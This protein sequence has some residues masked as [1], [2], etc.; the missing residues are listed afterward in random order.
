MAA[1]TTT[2][3]RFIGVIARA[4]MVT[5]ARHCAGKSARAFRASCGSAA[6]SASRSSSTRGSLLTVD[7]P[8]DDAGRVAE[9]FQELPEDLHEGHRAVPAAGAAD[10][11]GEVGLAL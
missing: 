5:A 11:D 1:I 2:R 10:G 4:A 3:G 8:M 7:V 9:R 6:A